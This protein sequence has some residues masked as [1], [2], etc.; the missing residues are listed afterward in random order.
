ML[1][2]YTDL[3]LLRTLV[4]K[5]VSFNAPNDNPTVREILNDERWM[6][7]GKAKSMMCAAALIRAGFRDNARW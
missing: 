6:G 5:K 1:D 2:W 7:Q 3:P 4:A